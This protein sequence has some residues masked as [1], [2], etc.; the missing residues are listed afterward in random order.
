[1]YRMRIGGL[2]PVRRAWA[3]QID[4]RQ[5]ALSRQSTPV[6]QLSRRRLS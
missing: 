3:L 2:R 5:R 1:L 4:Q 6:G